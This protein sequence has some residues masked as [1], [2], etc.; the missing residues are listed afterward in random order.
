MSVFNIL[1]PNLESW[2][3]VKIGADSNVKSPSIMKMVIKRI[4]RDYELVM[5]AMADLSRS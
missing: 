3:I 4:Y 5:D 2:G 1:F